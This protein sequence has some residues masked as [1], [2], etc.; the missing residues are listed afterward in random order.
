MAN[1]SLCEIQWIDDKG[2]PTP[3]T[4]PAIQRVRTVARDEM[5]AGRLCHFTGSEWFYICAEHSKRLGDPG[6]HIWECT[7]LNEEVS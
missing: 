2:N 6:M 5:I 3:D 1:H 7:P 4:N